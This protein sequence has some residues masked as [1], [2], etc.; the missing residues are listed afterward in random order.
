MPSNLPRVVGVSLLTGLATFFCLIPLLAIIGMGLIGVLLG[1]GGKNFSVGLVVSFLLLF[2]CSN[3]IYA[4]GLSLM[5]P[6]L[7]LGAMRFTQA[8]VAT[9]L[10][11][12]AATIL[13][14]GFSVV[15]RGLG[16]LVEI[17][18]FLALLVWL[19]PHLSSHQV[20]IQAAVVVFAGAALLTV[21]A[22]LLA[23]GPGEKAK[24]VAPPQTTPTVTTT[25][26]AVVKISPPGHIRIHRSGRTLLVTWKNN[27]SDALIMINAKIK[28]FPAINAHYTTRVHRAY[29]SLP[30][31]SGQ[32]VVSVFAL[33]RHG[34]ESA[35]VRLIAGG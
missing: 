21:S 15:S 34:E 16:A 29:V 35:K 27:R 10:A 11:S 12:V 28:G 20:P 2:I 19:L 7:G 22:S 4:L 6:R 26:T 30:A 18:A 14:L 23:L 32:V 8:L 3:L 31:D 33:G 5:W 24:T 17:C 9:L 1:A 13:Y 25:T